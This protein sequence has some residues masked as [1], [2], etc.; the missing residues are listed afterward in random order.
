MYFLWKSESFDAAFLAFSAAAASSAAIISSRMT[1][2]FSGPLFAAS[3][4]SAS[5]LRP[6][7]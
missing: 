2:A 5:A 1:L 4:S 3:E 6:C 7:L